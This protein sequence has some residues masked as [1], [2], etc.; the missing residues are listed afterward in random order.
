VEVYNRSLIHTKKPVVIMATITLNDGTE[1]HVDP[2]DLPYLSQFRWTRLKKA[3]G[4]S[5]AV[6]FSN[7][8]TIFMHRE[9]AET[10]AGLVC[11]HISGEGLDNRRCNLRNITRAENNFNRRAHRNSTSRFV[12]V[13]WSSRYRKWVSQIGVCKQVLFLGAFDDEE[14]AARVR[15]CAAFGLWG[16]LAR[17]NLPNQ[18]E[19]S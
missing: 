17:L 6:R 1:A 3:S 9:V 7:G 2:E 18:L 5:Y 10:P 4:N 12:G 8:R 14:E 11:D 16:E 13:S 19:C 15:D